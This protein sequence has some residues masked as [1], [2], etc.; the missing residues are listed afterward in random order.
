MSV[1]FLPI[2]IIWILSEIVLNIMKR[3]Q[4]RRSR[5][6]DRSSLTVLWVT[7]FISVT[8][9]VSFG[10]SGIGLIRPGYIIISTAG[11]IMIILGLAIRWIAIFALNRYFT[12][13]VAIEANHKIVETGPYRYVRHPAYA[14]SLLSFLGLGLAF[15][16]WLSML[17]IFIP[18]LT[19]FLYRIKV[20]EQALSEAFS[21]AYFKFASKTRR[22]IP[23]IY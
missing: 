6:L 12:V 10:M 15:S 21:S 5:H 4:K 8:A 19:A 16:N 23:G 20:E 2:S 17:I 1:L 11:I 13:D 22:L 3:S 9:G 18:I 7:I 14:G